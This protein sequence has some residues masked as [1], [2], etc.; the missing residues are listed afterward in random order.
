MAYECGVGLATASSRLVRKSR[1]TVFTRELSPFARL[2]SLGTALTE[3]LI[4]TE[5]RI[6]GSLGQ[7]RT[8]F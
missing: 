7:M 3:S 1:E 8:V 4:F 5:E 6:A 2:P